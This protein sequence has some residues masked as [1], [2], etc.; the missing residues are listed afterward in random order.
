MAKRLNMNLQT[1]EVTDSAGTDFGVHPANFPLGSIESRAA[2]RA[3]IAAGR[4][5]AGDTGT[6]K[7][8][9]CFMVTEAHNNKGRPSGR[10]VQFIFPKSWVDVPLTG[11]AEHGHDFEVTG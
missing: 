10:L 4:W 6:F 5:R 7:C 9:C 1:G 8:G 11:E 3:L 2:A